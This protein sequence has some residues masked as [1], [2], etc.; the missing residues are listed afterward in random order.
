M[1]RGK[2][3]KLGGKGKKKKTNVQKDD[4]QFVLENTSFDKNRIKA[5]H[6]VRITD[7]FDNH[8]SYYFHLIVLMSFDLYFG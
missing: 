6:E 1:P 8:I 4:H 3:T 7:T 2:R 5:F